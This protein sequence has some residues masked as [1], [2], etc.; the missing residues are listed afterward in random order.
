MCTSQVFANEQLSTCTN[1]AENFLFSIDEPYLQ[2][3]IA[4]SFCIFIYSEENNLDVKF[5]HFLVFFFRIKES[6]ENADQ[7]SEV[8]DLKGSYGSNGV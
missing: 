3:S 5:K 2:L 4:F 6:A 1:S 8:V 7:I